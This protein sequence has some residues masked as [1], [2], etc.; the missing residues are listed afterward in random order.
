M[1]N[2]ENQNKNDWSSNVR[3][4]QDI[5]GKDI[6]NRAHID[7]FEKLPEEEL[8]SENDFIT[9]MLGR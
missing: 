6:S 5:L 7:P 3:R 4:F 1:P 8:V 9:M 2:E